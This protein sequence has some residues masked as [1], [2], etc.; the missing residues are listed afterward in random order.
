MARA[1]PRTSS[2][3]WP[4]RENPD[5]SSKS[6][7]EGFAYLSVAG[8]AA[9]SDWLVFTLISWSLPGQ[10]VVLAQ[11]CARLTG[12]LVAFLLH[13]SWSFGHQQGHGLDVEARRFLTLYVFSFGLSIATMYILV[14]VF[15]AN[16]YWSKAAADT[17]CFVVNFLVMKFYVF[18]S[19]RDR[20]LG[21]AN[22]A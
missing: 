8:L 6:I 18:A 7:K 17:L 9:L 15:G 10:D 1:R 4:A 13:R 20:S 5:V 11:A 16:R 12:G 19:G 22:G 14:D 3:N 2:W 21:D